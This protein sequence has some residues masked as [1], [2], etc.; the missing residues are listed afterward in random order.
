RRIQRV[1]EL[2]IT[3][4]SLNRPPNQLPRQLHH[5]PNKLLPRPIRTRAVRG[6]REV[7]AR[8]SLDGHLARVVGECAYERD[9]T[10]E[11][12]VDDV[13]RL[14][15]GRLWRRRHPLVPREVLRLLVLTQPTE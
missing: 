12:V 10:C 14:L 13:Q 11:R 8:R 5:M 2:H 3:R 4:T 9:L 7:E 1:I 6:G 15:R